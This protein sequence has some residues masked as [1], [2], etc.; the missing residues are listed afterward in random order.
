VN[1][2]AHAGSSVQAC[3]ASGCHILALEGDDDMFLEFLIQFSDAT[4]NLGM[5]SGTEENPSGENLKELRT[6]IN[7]EQSKSRAAASSQRSNSH[8]L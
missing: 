2:F 5:P 3:V 8:A 6:F 1:A 4:D 7:R